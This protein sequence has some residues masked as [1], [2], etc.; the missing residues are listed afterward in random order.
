MAYAWS[1]SDGIGAVPQQIRCR[2]QTDSLT[3]FVNA[4]D[5]STAPAVGADFTLAADGLITEPMARCVTAQM[6]LAGS[7]SNRGIVIR[8][9]GVNQFGVSVQENLDFG[10]QA[11]GTTYIMF[12][13]NAFR[14]I[15]Q[16]TYLSRNGAAAVAND[17]VKVGIVTL[18]ATATGTFVS[19]N[20]AASTDYKAFGLPG[21]LSSADGLGTIIAADF[22]TQ[23]HGTII[24]EDGTSGVQTW[25]AMSRNNDMK[26]DATFHT[27]TIDEDPVITLGAGASVI[28]AIITVTTNTRRTENAVLPGSTPI[29]PVPPV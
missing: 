12:T 11:N 16:V 27:L 22:P 2:W 14:F 5:I 28:E 15:S 19:T 21:V 29:N 7:G 9:R 18:G 24:T 25:T 20:G 4:T 3:R 26:A 13:R 6:I 1:I 23:L 8:I 17:A 10:S